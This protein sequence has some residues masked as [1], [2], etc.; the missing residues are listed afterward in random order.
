MKFH[1]PY[2]I[3][4]QHGNAVYWYLFSLRFSTKYRLILC[5][6]RPLFADASCLVQ[7]RSRIFFRKGTLDVKMIEMIFD[8]VKGRLY[9][10]SMC[11]SNL[12]SLLLNFSYPYFHENTHHFRSP[13]FYQDAG[14]VHLAGGG[15]VPSHR[16][17]K[18][19]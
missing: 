15:L 14:C 9:N 17:R 11:F 8:E 3:H 1:S 4:M 6:N 19:G 10:T 5:N 13:R 12:I 7:W 18:R 2:P 16:C